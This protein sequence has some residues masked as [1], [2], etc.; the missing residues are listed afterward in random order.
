MSS[1]TLS[2][3]S[4]GIGIICALME[5][6]AAM[7]VMLDE[8]HELL[9]QKSGDRNSYTLGRIGKHNVVIACLLEGHQG[10]AAAATVA[11]HMMYSFPIKLGL[12]VGI[13]GGVPSQVP[14]IRLGDVVVS[15][16][17]S[18]H[19]GVIQYDLGKLESDGF[20]RKGHLDKPPKA[21][22]GAVTTLRAKHEWKDPEFH[23]YLTTIAKN[24]GNRRMATKYGFQGA[25]QDRLFDPG[26]IHPRD[27]HT[28]D[29]CVLT[30][31][32]VQRA[33]RDDNT[34]H[35]FYGTILS[36]DLVM[37]NGE[38]RDRRAAADK[39]MCFEMEAAGLMNDFPCL[40]I[41]GISDYSD[42]HKNDRWQ[43]YAAATA[44]AY[45]KKLLGV[46]SA[47]EIE[48]L[49]PAKKHTIPFS[50]KGVPAIDHFVQRV[51]DMQ[52]LEEY[53][54]PQKSDLTR[55]KMFVVHGL[56]GIGKTQ[57]CIEFVRRYQDKYS[58]VFW[59]DGSSEDAL[60]RSF[61][62]IIARLPADEVP[63]GLVHAAEEAG[64]DQRLIVQGVLD[65][66]SL[67]SNRQWLVVI[68]NADRDHETKVR[69]PLAY[70]VKQYLP[71][72]DH[73]NVLVTSRLST[74]TVPRNSLRITE[75]DRD[76]G[77]AILEAIGGDTML[78]QDERS[79]NALLE[80]LSGLPLALTQ[81]AAY[82]G[83]TAV[84]IVQYLEYYDSMWNDMT[85]QQDEYP[86]QEYAQR[87]VLT[88]WKISYEQVKSQSEEVSNLLQLWSFLYAGDLWLKF[89][90]AL[91]LLIKYSLVEGKAETASYAIH[92]VLHSWCRYLGE[93]EAE[94]ESFWKLA[95]YIVEGMVP[96]ESTEE[97]WLLQRR[98]LPHGQTILHGMR[99]KTR[100]ATAVNETWIYENL[101]GM[102]ADQD[103]YKEAEELY[104]RSL[105]GK[106]KALGPEHTF[107][108][109]TVHNLGNL[110]L[111]QGRH[112]EAE[113]MY[114]RALA[115]KEKAL[116]PEHT[117]TLRTVNNLGILYKAQGKLAEAGQM[118]KRALAGYEKAL[119]AEHTDTLM[120]VNNLGVL[121]RGQDRLAEAEAMYK[122]ALAGKE[123]ALGPEHTSAVD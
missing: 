76:Q 5:E 67:P 37:K 108:L 15:M 30:L 58:A 38:E 65:W 40:V 87:S 46:L 68:D 17:E 7:E 78:A 86:L 19:G 28:C 48:K 114:K 85:E 27:R 32:T 113:A 2:H 111:D 77:R 116:G 109:D 36:G 41:R 16:P 29:H 14:T 92:S 101:A 1:T 3:A 70:D 104:E 117:S 45:A 24:R 71:A 118:Y 62:D 94:R 18:T 25:Q 74:L 13:G 22:L 23:R 100:A 112:A 4:Y 110:Y 63:L 107:S 102:F 49:G 59:L 44:A 20:R 64:P 91:S 89:D 56:G 54:F 123:K 82:I 106:E 72:V 26:E 21:L 81:A 103:R 11:V 57:L 120:I 99:S 119:G 42:L 34:P 35:V 60:Q 43:P 105:A 80:R 90:R 39:A 88:T 115:G 61:V 121:Y 83:Q 66:L 51:S 52:R 97:Y 73:G 95:V 79:V 12:M 75:V 31:R 93:S 84:S 98:L 9:E 55:R 33:H 50:L 122:R 69:D 10:K 6:K 47:Q 8:E 96:S 53:F